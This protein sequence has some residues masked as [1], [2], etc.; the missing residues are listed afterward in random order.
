MWLL[1]DWSCWTALSYCISDSVICI[2]ISPWATFGNTTI[3]GY[4]TLGLRMPWRLYKGIKLSLVGQNLPAQQH[5]KTEP[6]A[7]DY[8]I[9]GKISWGFW[10]MKLWARKIPPLLLSLGL[11]LSTHLPML[12]QSWQKQAILVLNIVCFTTWST[13]THERCHQFFVVG[14]NAMQ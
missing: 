4:V 8:G 13:K 2:P 5:P 6:T 12:A 14:D 7:I 9:Y 1:I 3:K 11:L 10:R